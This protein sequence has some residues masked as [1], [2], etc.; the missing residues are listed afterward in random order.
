MKAILCAAVLGFGF[1]GPAMAQTQVSWYALND[2]GHWCRYP[3][4]KAWLDSNGHES[5]TVDRR[6]GQVIAVHVNESDDSGD[7]TANDDYI[8]ANGKLIGLRRRYN[9]FD[10]GE[11]A[12][13]ESW[14]RVG[15]HWVRTQRS[16]S[17]FSG[18]HARKD[19]PAIVYPFKKV[20]RLED[21]GFARLLKGEAKA[22]TCL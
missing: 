6:S 8:V 21:F 22:K 20:E 15:T 4:E 18:D 13:V 7:W 3:T 16:L 11:V 14:R 19:D 17:D 2:N 12:L 10:H 5:A 9:T 1:A